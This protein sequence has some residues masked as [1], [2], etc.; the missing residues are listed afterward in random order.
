MLKLETLE[1]LNKKLYEYRENKIKKHNEKS[2]YHMKKCADCI[3]KYASNWNRMK[4][5]YHYRQTI[6]HHKRA[7]SYEAAQDYVTKKA[8]E[9]NV[10][11]A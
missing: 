7:L 3:C 2:E 10:E 4:V 9:L 8:K 11:L 6:Y 1:K 5:D